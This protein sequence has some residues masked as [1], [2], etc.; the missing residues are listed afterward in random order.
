MPLIT[1]RKTGKTLKEGDWISIDGSTG[2][3]F[4]GQANTLDADPSS[5]VLKTFMQWADSFRGTFGV[6]ANADIPRDAQA[7]RKFG[8]EGIGLC[9]T[10]HMFFAEGRI[11]HMQAMN[12]SLLNRLRPM[13]LGHVPLENMLSELVQDRAEHI[14][15]SLHPRHIRGHRQGSPAA[16]ADFLFFVAHLRN[17]IGQEAHVGF[18]ACRGGIDVRLDNGGARGCSGIN[19]FVHERVLKEVTV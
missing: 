4:A 14:A 13:A 8:A 9:R 2:E 6:R 18:K 17:Q 5:G 1:I 19:A 12:R 3:V 10:E 11:E 16:L 7:A 15:M